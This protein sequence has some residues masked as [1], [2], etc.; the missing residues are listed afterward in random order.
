MES[1]VW[2]DLILAALVLI[3]GIKGLMNGFIK[4]VFGIIGLIG[5]VI[6][7]S[8]YATEVGE[9][10]SK[11]VYA[12]QETFWFHLGFLVTLIAFWLLCLGLGYIFSKMLSMSGF[13][14][15]DR[16]LGFIVGS[17]KIF[18]VFAIFVFI[19]SNIKIINEKLEPYTKNS[20]FYPIL[21]Q[22]GEFIM[23]QSV[24]TGNLSDMNGSIGNIKNEISEQVQEQIQEKIQDATNAVNGEN[25]E[26]NATIL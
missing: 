6:V 3:L 22:S 5:G 11:N 14:F 1:F 21:L 4:E 24:K 23:N 15:I 12:V 10:V 16:L 13:S 8:R 17:A 25:N 18:L 2:F 19:I 9:L 7:A 20:F 26:T